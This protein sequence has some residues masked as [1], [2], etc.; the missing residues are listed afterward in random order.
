MI[1]LPSTSKSTSRAIDRGRLDLDAEALRL[2]AEFGELVGV[3]H[4][5]RHR[6]GEE[7]DRIIRL[8]IGGLIGDQRV[9]R[10][11]ALVEAV[12]GEAFEQIEDG[13]G[14]VFLDA[15][16]DRARDE[17]GALRAHLLADLLAHGAAQKIGLAEREAGQDLRGLHHLFLV[18]D[19]A[20]GLLQDR[21]ELGMD[22]VRLLH[23]VLARAIG[24]DV[25]HRAGPVER[26]Q[27][28]DVLETVGPHVEQRA[29]H[30][31]A[32]QLEHADRFRA[33]QQVVGFLVVERD[34]GEIDRRCRAAS[35]AR[36]RSAAPSSVFRP[37]KSNFT[38]PACSTHFMLNWVTGMSD[39]G[40]R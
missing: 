9:G 4:V 2:G 32:F 11:V 16:L 3:A 15:A 10:G 5:E 13:V 26:D 25:R 37:R 6:G 38:S 19:D 36:P 14:L 33:R 12:F 27:R 31:R 35:P 7:L 1:V 8:H 20:E 40:S 23:A 29:P 17:D 21:L 30:A 34:G 22:V 28:D 18:D 39:F 24:R